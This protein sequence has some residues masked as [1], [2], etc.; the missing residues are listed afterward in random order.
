MMDRLRNHHKRE[1][2]EDG[3]EPTLITMM[4]I[5][6]LEGSLVMSWRRTGTGTDNNFIRHWNNTNSPACEAL[7]ELTQL[8]SV[9]S[10]ECGSG[11]KLVVNIAAVPLHYCE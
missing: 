4:Q 7:D 2:Q 6:P 3:K 8:I 5:T 11:W 10:A 9:V 1:E